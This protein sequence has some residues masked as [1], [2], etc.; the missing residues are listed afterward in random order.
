MSLYNLLLPTFA[1]SAQNDP[2]H[3]SLS[4]YFDALWGKAQS[5]ELYSFEGPNSKVFHHFNDRAHWF[6]SRTIVSHVEGRQ[7]KVFRLKAGLSED[8]AGASRNCYELSGLTITFDENGFHFFG[9]VPLDLDFLR[10]PDAPLAQYHEEMRGLTYCNPFEGFTFVSDTIF[11]NS[12]VSQERIQDALGRFAR[13]FS[14]I[15][16]LS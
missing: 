6:I 10:E 16:N 4:N 7:A 1:I 15:L 11:R 13:D 12:G 9:I 8:L 3:E 2:S 14:V 5:L